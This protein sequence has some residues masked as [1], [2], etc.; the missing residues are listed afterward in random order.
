MTPCAGWGQSAAAVAAY[1]RA[2][3]LEPEHPVPILGVCDA[4]LDADE[5]GEAQAWVSRIEDPSDA[6]A[7]T[8]AIALHTKD[9]AG[10]LAAYR[11]AVTDA[12]IADGLAD[13]MISR[14]QQAELGEKAMRQLDGGV[15]AGTLLPRGIWHWAQVQVPGGWK[16][17]V[18]A[19]PRL[20]AAGSAHAAAALRVVVEHAAENGR[21]SD[22]D[23]LLK[24]HTE[25]LAADRDCWSAVGFGLARSGRWRRCQ[26]WLSG[27]NKPEPFPFT[28]YNLAL[29]HRFLLEPGEAAA[30][31][32]RGLDLPPDHTTPRLRVWAAYDAAIAGRVA[33]A[34]SLLDSVDP[35]V[36]L[37]PLELVVASC[38]DAVAAA[39]HAGDDWQS[40]AKGELRRAKRAIKA[41][42]TDGATQ[43]LA[44]RLAR[45]AIGAVIRRHGDGAARRWWRWCWSSLLWNMTPA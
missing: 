39:A 26:E 42:G 12:E 15:E 4:W 23:R 13:F 21:W 27:P 17:V 44:L 8:F 29:A 16:K 35:E 24:R 30:V 11:R 32:L 36:E 28:L 43:A 20:A 37:S 22:F 31:T 25:L 6:L 10:A 3:A 19:L 18:A 33:E 40:A 7:R 41:M 9:E 1:E 45:E 2:H 38:T 34:S 14:L 5:Y